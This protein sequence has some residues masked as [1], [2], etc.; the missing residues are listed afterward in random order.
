MV[1]ITAEAWAQLAGQLVGDP[2]LVAGLPGGLSPQVQA[3]IMNAPEGE[4]LT[5]IFQGREIMV[6]PAQGTGDMG[7][8]GGSTNG[9]VL[10]SGHGGG[11]QRPSGWPP[12]VANVL[13]TGG[14]I[15]ELAEGADIRDV[16]I[17]GGGVGLPVGPTIAIAR[18]LL[19]AAM[20]G[21]T[22]ITRAHWNRLPGWAQSL[23]AGVGL[24]VG[25]D[26]AL[27]VPGI[28]G[29][30]I[31]LGGGGGGGPDLHMGQHLTDGHLGV[32]VVGGWVANGVQFYRLSDGKLAV[33]NSKGRW[34]VW[35]PK[36]PIVLYSGGAVNL[37][38]LLRAD[39]VLNRQAKR[40]AAMLNRRA[41]RA[42]RSGKGAGNAPVI[43]QADGKVVNT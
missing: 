12:E 41:P 42:K 13:E 26:L 4:D 1:E 16:Q 8:V 25:I 7:D 19:R 39:A 40:I 28:P 11:Q 23:L 31:I 9:E 30:S 20:G 36:K 21:A 32:T 33:Q 18:T 37:K 3:A 35:R 10:P 17:M 14:A 27:D 34:K 5:D 43:I 2:S 15:L 22:R 6:D 24:G 29:E 38:T